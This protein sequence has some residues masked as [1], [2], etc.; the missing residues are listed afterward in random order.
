MVLFFKRVTLQHGQWFKKLFCLYL[1]EAHDGLEEAHDG[2]HPSTH[3]WR[4]YDR[5][6][7]SWSLE[8]GWPKA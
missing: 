1:K 8:S 6:A 4:S 3:W 2:L 5:E 7:L